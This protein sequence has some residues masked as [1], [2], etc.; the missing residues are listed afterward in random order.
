MDTGAVPAFVGWLLWAM[1]FCLAL[2][3]SCSADATGRRSA[4]G[5]I[6][7]WQRRR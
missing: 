4:R 7:A 5:T 2:A 1:V 3:Y 6:G